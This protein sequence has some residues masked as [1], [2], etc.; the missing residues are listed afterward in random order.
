MRPAPARANDRERRENPPG[1]RLRGDLRWERRDWRIVATSLATV[2][3]GC[4]FH[5]LNN[6]S[7][8]RGTGSA[9]FRVL[10]AGAQMCHLVSAPPEWLRRAIFAID[11]LFQRANPSPRIDDLP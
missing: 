4:N 8:S 3:S 7:N 11:S 2:S 5:S 1:Y 6:F 9:V 10:G